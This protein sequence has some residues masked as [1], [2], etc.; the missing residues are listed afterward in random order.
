MVADVPWVHAQA[1][2][3]F[4]QRQQWLIIPMQ[5]N[6][7]YRNTDSVRLALVQPVAIETEI[8]LADR[9]AAG[10]YGNHEDWY[11]Q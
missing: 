7:K 2:G 6:R 9:T 5:K 4:G 3:V 8:P 10:C 1:E 11:T